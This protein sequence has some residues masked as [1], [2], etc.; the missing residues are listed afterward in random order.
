MTNKNKN[1]TLYLLLPSGY[2]PIA[3]KLDWIQDPRIVGV[4]VRSSVDQNCNVKSR[5]GIGQK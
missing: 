1:K 2:H 3:S 5:P 4:G